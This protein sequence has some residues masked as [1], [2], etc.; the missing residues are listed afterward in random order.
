MTGRGSGRERPAGLRRPGAE[1]VAPSPLRD[2]DARASEASPR[3][4]P[5]PFEAQRRV[6]AQQGD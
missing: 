5:D 2:R 4:Q 3:P 6:L 1:D